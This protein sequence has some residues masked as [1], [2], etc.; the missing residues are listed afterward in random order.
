[1][2]FPESVC[3]PPPPC[4][5]FCCEPEDLSFPKDEDR[6]FSNVADSSAA[7]HSLPPGAKESADILDSSFDLSSVEALQSAD[8]FSMACTLAEIFASDAPGRQQTV[9]DLPVLLQ[10]RRLLRNRSR[11]HSVLTRRKGGARKA[12]AAATV[13]DASVPSSV[14]SGSSDRLQSTGRP[15]P[16]CHRE[17]RG[18]SPISAPRRGLSHDEEKESGRL[19][20]EEREQTAGYSS[21]FGPT[22]LP[23]PE[24]SSVCS[25]TQGSPKEFARGQEAGAGDGYAVS[26]RWS[27]HVRGG[28]ALPSSPVPSPGAPA[29]AT[30]DVGVPKLRALSYALSAIRSRRIREALQNHVLLRYPEMRLTASECLERWA[31]S[32]SEDEA[33]FPPCFL[34]YF[35][36][37]F[38]VLTHPAYQQPDLRIL[39]IRHWLPHILAAILQTRRKR[40]AG[41]DESHE[42][43]A[44]GGER[45]TS[46]SATPSAEGEVRCGVVVGAEGSRE[47]RQVV[48]V[49]EEAVEHHVCSVDPQVAYQVRRKKD[50]TL[51]LSVCR[52]LLTDARR[53]MASFCSGLH[54]DPW[55]TRAHL[56]PSIDPVPPVMAS[57]SK[58]CSAVKI[59]QALARR[60]SYCFALCEGLVLLLP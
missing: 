3:G 36:P 41:E 12:D 51:A 24:S 31:G 47:E 10:L 13:G 49:L 40:R 8:V 20:A 33:F 52:L 15:R 42:A 14:V 28:N 45:T 32:R 26:S 48:Q 43:H 59:S 17:S 54:F 57:I 60:R 22:E 58:V 23:P 11:R 18:G 1:M 37:L 27:S 30:D 53:A 9:I 21:P 35:L 34:S 19:T 46:T 50:E 6:G 5:R 7:L 25:D 4:I 29:C 38:T 56:S 16:E 44:S 55:T 2:L 39:L